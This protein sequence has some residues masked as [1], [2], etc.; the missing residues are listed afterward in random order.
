MKAN[1]PGKKVWNSLAASISW[2]YRALVN[3]LQVIA[4]AKEGGNNANSYILEDGR[5]DAARYWADRHNRFRYSFRG[6]G[7]TSRSEVENIRDYTHAVEAIANLLRSISCEPRGKTMLD[8]GCG[9]GFWTGIFQ[10]WGVARYTGIDIT[11]ALFGQLRDRYPTLEFIAGD[12]PKLSLRSRFQIVT[13]IDVS[14]HVTSDTELQGMLAEVRSLLAKD[15]VFIVTFWNQE[16]PQENFYEA[17]RLFGFYTAALNGMAH[18]EPMQFRDKFIAAFYDPERQSEE[19]SA[20]PLA[21]E[22][23]ASIVKQILAI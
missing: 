19:V 21:R 12:L 20:Q 14:Q 10:K 22:D 2:R 9:N 8:I 5:Y 7:N 15:G 4:H 18:T 1:T 17:F 16:R 3:R 11:D 13:M 6:V 23:I